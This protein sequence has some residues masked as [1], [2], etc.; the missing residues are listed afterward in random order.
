MSKLAEDEVY[1]D[2]QICLKKP[3]I[4][5][6]YFIMFMV[7]AATSILSAVRNTINVAIIA[8]VKTPE[9]NSTVTINFTYHQLETQVG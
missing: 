6:R 5:Y 3:L 9:E 7:L 2:H 1:L 4:P 8:M